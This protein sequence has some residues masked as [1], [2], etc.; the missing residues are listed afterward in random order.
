MTNS[1]TESNI[2]YNFKDRVALI[3]GGS[4]GIGKA[5]VDQFT[6]SGAKTFYVSRTKIE[7]ETDAIHMKCDL[8][9]E[10][11]IDSLLDSLNKFETIPVNGILF[12]KAV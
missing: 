2:S 10:S 6:K 8:S 12:L 7:K 4:R 5:V 11:T 1:H 9:N 3:I